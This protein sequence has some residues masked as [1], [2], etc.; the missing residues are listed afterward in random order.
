MLLVTAQSILVTISGLYAHLKVAGGR[1]GAVTTPRIA[2]HPP[3]LAHD[4][5]PAVS[6]G[7]T[8]PHRETAGILVLRMLAAIAAVPA[9]E[10]MC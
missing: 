6:V 4:K 10:S 5:M 2:T 7:V 3:S 9:S 1:V 8:Y